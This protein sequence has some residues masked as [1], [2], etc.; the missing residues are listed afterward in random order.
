MEAFEVLEDQNGLGTFVDHSFQLPEEMVFSESS[1]Q[2]YF[3]IQLISETEG[4]HFR[5][6]V[7]FNH[8]MLPI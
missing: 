4:L 3:D 8:E 6:V 5:H 1:E 2:V 7:A